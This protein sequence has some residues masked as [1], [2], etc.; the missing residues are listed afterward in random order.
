MVGEGGEISLKE[1]KAPLYVCASVDID[2]PELETVYDRA[3]SD[4]VR[5]ERE[6]L[7]DYEVGEEITGLDLTQEEKSAVLQITNRVFRDRKL[8]Y[9]SCYIDRLNRQQ[10][11][12][13]LYLDGNSQLRRAKQRLGEDLRIGFVAD[14]Q[15]NGRYKTRRKTSKGAGHEGHNIREPHLQRGKLV[16]N[17]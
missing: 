1:N 12:Y 7:L 16:G 5:G 8:S 15:A 10:V 9:Q 6:T 11:N 4:I 14:L 2:D 13:G 3:I 17:F